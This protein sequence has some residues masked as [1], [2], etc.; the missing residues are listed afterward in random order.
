M[1]ITNFQNM[2]PIGGM[3]GEEHCNTIDDTFFDQLSLLSNKVLFRDRSHLALE[4]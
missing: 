3:D 4:F 2:W 1:Q